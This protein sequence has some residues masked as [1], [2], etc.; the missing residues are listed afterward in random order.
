MRR[1][2]GQRLRR[3]DGILPAL[4]ALA[5][6]LCRSACT[7]GSVGFFKAQNPDIAK[8]AVVKFRH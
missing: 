3:Q 2:R 1:R 5:L 6:G 8:V 7:G 4:L